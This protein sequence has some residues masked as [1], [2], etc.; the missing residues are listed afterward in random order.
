MSGHHSWTFAPL[1][2]STL[3]GCWSGLPL[4]PE[5]IPQEV[6]EVDADH[7]GYSE[8]GHPLADVAPGT[9][10]D[11]LSQ[12]DG[13]WGRFENEVVEASDSTESYEIRT[14]EVWAVDAANRRIWQYRLSRSD[15][16]LTHPWI[17]YP[18][19]LDVEL[20]EYRILDENK[21]E[22]EYVDGQAGA[23]DEQGNL[24]FYRG[25]LVSA[26]FNI[27]LVLES[28]V[29]IQGDFLLLDDGFVSE[30][31]DGTAVSLWRRL[32]ECAIP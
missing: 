4:L 19:L 26:G 31:P 7:E 20:T 27:G 24:V 25:A 13:C 30:P 17:G 23:I 12:L 6:L 29:T 16:F 1:L 5:E 22:R 15:A 10:I 9:V 2:L 32:P 18:A 11:D 3:F 28:R 8:D 14:S 21:I